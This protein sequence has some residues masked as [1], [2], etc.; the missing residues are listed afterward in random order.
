MRHVK[1]LPIA[2]VFK[3]SDGIRM[4]TV[5]KPANACKRVRIRVL[6]FE[7]TKPPASGR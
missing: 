4:D 1:A 3:Y 5:T 6:Y 7:H 2:D